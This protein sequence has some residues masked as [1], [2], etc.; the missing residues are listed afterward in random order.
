MAHKEVTLALIEQGQLQKDFDKE[1]STA[2]RGMAEYV[3]K[4]SLR[5][6]G[7]VAEV[8]MKVKVKCVKAEADGSSQFAILGEVTSKKPAR[9]KVGTLAISGSLDEKDENRSLFCLASGTNVDSPNQMKICTDQGV[10][11]DLE[12]GEPIKD[13]DGATE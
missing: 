11:I 13:A 8:T 2:V 10:A 12:T 7:A 4:Y 6:E 9:P 3:R 5:A 1:M